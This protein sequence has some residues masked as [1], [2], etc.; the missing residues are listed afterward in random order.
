MSI[1]PSLLTGYNVT[2]SIGTHLLTCPP[3]STKMTFFLQMM[4]ALENSYFT[5]GV[6]TS[7]VGMV[8]YLV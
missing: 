6:G 5:D 4:K 3:A 1:T 2:L 8:D 7:K